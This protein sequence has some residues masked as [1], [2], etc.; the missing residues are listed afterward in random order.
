MLLTDNFFNE[1]KDVLDLL[2]YRLIGEDGYYYISQKTKLT[3]TQQQTFIQKNK[4][5]IIAISFLRQLYPRLEKG[6]VIYFLNT[7]GEYLNVKKENISI[8][9]KLVYLFGIK[10][11]EDEKLMLEQ[12]FKYLEDKNIIEKENDNN[13][14]KYKILNSISYYI[15]IVES[16]EKGDED[17]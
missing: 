17:A 4:E 3:S 10:N 6:G 15:S 8:K 7:V 11:Q 2:G 12:L 16:I 1:L 13:T 5:I 9:E 14:D